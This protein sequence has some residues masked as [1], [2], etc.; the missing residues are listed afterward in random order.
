MKQPKRLTYEQKR[1]VAKKGYDPSKWMFVEEDD[2]AI[3]IV[4]KETKEK[5]W[6]AK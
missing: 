3:L 6:V 4:N 5:E 2:V 1:H